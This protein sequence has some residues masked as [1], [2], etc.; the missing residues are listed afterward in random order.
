MR[1]RILYVLSSIDGGGVGKILLTYLSRLDKERF[2]CDIACL[3]NPVHKMLYYDDFKSVVNNIY[4]L[5]NS[6]L[7]RLQQFIRIISKRKYHI[8]HVHLEEAS[9]VYLLIGMLLGVRIRIAHSHLT[10]VPKTF[11]GRM[12]KFLRPLLFAVTTQKYA[13]G[14]MAFAHLWGKSKDKHIMTNAINVE[15]FLYNKDDENRVRKEFLIP[16]KNFIIGTVGRLSYQKNPSFIIEI[17]LELKR[18]EPN[19]SFLWVG[20]GEQSVSLRER[21]KCEG[22]DLNVIFTGNRKDIPQLFNAMKV[23]I[24]P[25]LYEGLPIVGV[26]AQASNLFCLFSDTI[27]R[28]IGLTKHID[29]LPIKSPAVWAG[30]IKEIVQRGYDREAES[31]IIKSKYN[32]NEAVKILETEYLQYYNNQYQKN[33]A[34]AMTL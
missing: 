17:L 11:G 8:L 18:T 26:E 15:K 9:A 23:F 25:S 4:F 34:A 10:T 5:N 1:I 32:I 29:F 14:K 13:C 20:D 31:G 22:L 7:K 30:K 6:Y 3:D 33:D 12:K 27:T 21:C 19:F 16:E 28:E 24:L 2:E